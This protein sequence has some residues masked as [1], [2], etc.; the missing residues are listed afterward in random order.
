[1]TDEE[2]CQ[3]VLSPSRTGSQ[4]LVNALAESGTRQV[5]HLHYLGS[6]ALSER[7]GELNGRPPS[8]M[9]RQAIETQAL[10]GAAGA[11]FKI[12]T[13]IRDPVARQI[14]HL[15]KFPEIAMVM[16]GVDVYRDPERARAWMIQYFHRRR[17]LTWFQDHIVEPFGVDLFN[18]PFDPA[19]GSLRLVRH[20]L[21]LVVVRLEDHPL[22]RQAALGWLLNRDALAIPVVD[23]GEDASYRNT[24]RKFMSSFHP[25]QDL[26]DDI[27]GS[28]MM[29]HFYSEE[30]RR[31]MR[32]H[33]EEPREGAEEISFSTPA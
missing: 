13:C 11:R 29:R 17:P 30:E 10:I 1:M 6:K 33:W 16:S 27:Y 28:R 22:K 24:Y 7:V 2:E 5:G 23:R 25:P 31:R 4:A 19:Q 21:R 8:P 14:S 12:A 3:L 9:L 15:F 32:D 26:L 18:V 20:D